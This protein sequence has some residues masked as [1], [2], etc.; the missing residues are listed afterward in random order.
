MFST[1]STDHVLLVEVIA[2]LG[3]FGISVGFPGGFIKERFGARV[4]AACG[5]ILSVTG[6][7]LLW[8]TCLMK[9]FYQDHVFLQYIYYF[10]AGKKCNSKAFI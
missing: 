3:N 7:L 1:V 5:L 9:D 8:S 2:S 6:F 4:A 10:I